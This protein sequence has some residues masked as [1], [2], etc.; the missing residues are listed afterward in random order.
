L[1]CHVIYN[2]VLIKF[3]AQ[4]DYFYY[5]NSMIDRYGDQSEVFGHDKTALT[6][7]DYKMVEFK[8]ENTVL[9]HL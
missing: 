4:K 5:K 3:S 2:Q 9:T 7:V 8:K 1:Q 6:T